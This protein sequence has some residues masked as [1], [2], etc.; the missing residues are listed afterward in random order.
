M[1]SYAATGNWREAASAAA[2]ALAA[3]V[4]AGA[5]VKGARF[6]VGAARALRAAR[7]ARR[8]R[9]AYRASR[10]TARASRYARRA[11]GSCFRNSFDA[12]TPVLLP[13]GEWIPIG[14]IQVGDVFEATDP[15]TGD[16]RP[17]PVLQ[18]IT[19]QGT[20]HM[21]EIQT[22]DG[23]A[24]GPDLQTTAAHPFLVQGRG[25]VEADQLRVGDLVATPDGATSPVTGVLDLGWLRDQVVVNLAVGDLHTYTV[26]TG[27]A[28]AVV[29]NAYCS[30]TLKTW[31][32]ARGAAKQM[33][34]R[35]R[36]KGYDARY[37]GRASRATTTIAICERGNPIPVTTIHFRWRDKRIF[38]WN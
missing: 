19:G 32:A 20:R 36:S 31:R 23:P 38:R 16:S 11:Y 26:W 30:K 5:A 6:A 14:E 33:A 7:A 28:P 12:A 10:A 15:Q 18:V 21:I 3:V 29:H 1:V 34:K 35:L 24:Q 2:G 17:E 8:A 25:R 27:H 22:G 13:G 9:A 37:R 4:G